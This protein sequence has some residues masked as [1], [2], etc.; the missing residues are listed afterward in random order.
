MRRGARSETGPHLRGSASRHRL[1]ARLVAAVLS[2]AGA[3]SW[4]GAAHAQRPAESTPEA[5][6]AADPRQLCLGPASTA[7]ERVAGCSA[8]IESELVQNNLLAAAY[9][10]R[11]FVFTLKRNLEQA[12]KDLD[13]AIKIA[14]DYAAAYIN[15]A[16][17]WTVSN[18][19]ERAIADAERALKLAPNAPLAYFVR[20]G[21][22]AKLGQYDKAIADYS[23]MLRLN[24]NAGESVYGPRGHAYYRKRDYDRAIADYDA[25]IELKPDDAGAYLNRGDALRSKGELAGAGE[26]Y[27]RAIRLAPDNPGG[28]SGRG[29]IRL[30][31][32]DFS[33]AVADFDTAIRLNPNDVNSY[34]NRGAALSLLGE[35]LRD[36]I[37]HECLTLS[38]AGLSKWLFA[39]IL[40]FIVFH[41]LPTST[42]IQ[43]N[44]WGTHWGRG[45][46]RWRGKSIGLTRV[47]SARSRKTAATRMVAASICQS[48]QM[49]AGGGFSCIAGTASPPKS[50]S[51]RHVTLRWR[52]LASWRRTH[53][54]GWQRASIRREP[55][56]R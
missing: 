33:G 21:G 15:R 23:E 19:P 55:A 47:Q 12:Q 28:F 50:G 34:I 20:A 6:Q 1:A 46:R 35:N 8:V 49:A 56:S 10:Q 51:A 24:P 26:D 16:N 32:H 11:G 45:G 53:E 38:T 39:S 37:V 3:V 29:Q 4:P 42:T 43:R 30:L 2:L 54:A 22:E 7:D 41:C 17:F 44:C 25:L 9:A 18:Q 36:T 40:A 27:G 52:A 5:A 31:T 13:Q 14:P 48:R